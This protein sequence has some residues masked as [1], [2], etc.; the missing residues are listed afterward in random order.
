MVDLVPQVGDV[1]GGRLGIE[2]PTVDQLE[3]PRPDV[4]DDVFSPR[5]PTPRLQ[6]A[7]GRVRERAR[8]VGEDLEERH[9]FTLG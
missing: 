4:E 5:G 8:D 2:G 3:G 6:R 7:E 9:R 1:V